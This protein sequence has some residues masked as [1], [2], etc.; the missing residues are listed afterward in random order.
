MG[1]VSCCPTP[2]PRL[3]TRPSC[4][5]TPSILP[6]TAISGHVKPVHCRASVCEWQ[7]PPLGKQ[8]HL[9]A[10]LQHPRAFGPPEPRP[11]QMGTLAAFVRGEILA[12]ATSIPAARR[13]LAR[14]SVD[15]GTTTRQQNAGPYWCERAPTRRRCRPPMRARARPRPGSAPGPD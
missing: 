1:M 12:C 4:G 15:I 8:R 5:R 14:G 3:R 6:Q 10:L 2:H 9:S 7:L 13:G 11:C